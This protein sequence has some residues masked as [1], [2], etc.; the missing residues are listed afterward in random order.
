MNK[1]A[2]KQTN[3]HHLLKLHTC[4]QSTSAKYTNMHEW[5]VLRHAFLS[6]LWFHLSEY[7]LGIQ[8]ICIFVLK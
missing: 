4:K 1:Y 3:K 2:R 7:I 8:K 6:K 5:F